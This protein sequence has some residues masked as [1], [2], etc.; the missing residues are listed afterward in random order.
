M[1]SGATLEFRNKSWTLC[2]LAAV[3]VRPS[4]GMGDEEDVDSGQ[5]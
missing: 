5:S 2:R 3:A 1:L 4:R